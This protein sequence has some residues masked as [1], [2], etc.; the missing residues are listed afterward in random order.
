[1]V[2]G[3]GPAGQHAAIHAAKH[4]KNV[5][6]VERKPRIGGAGLQTHHSQQSLA[7]DCLQHHH[8]SQPWDAQRLSGY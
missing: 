6:L 7:G 2:I 4:G 5:A 8:R 3:S 1:L